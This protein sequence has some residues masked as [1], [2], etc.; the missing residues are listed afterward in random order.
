MCPN[1]HDKDYK[2]LIELFGEDGALAAYKLNGEQIPDKE[3]AIELIHDNAKITPALTMWDTGTFGGKPEKTTEPIID[4]LILSDPDAKVGGG[5]SFNEVKNRGLAAATDIMKTAPNGAIVVTNSSVLKFVLLWDKMGRPS[6]WDGITAKD[7]LKESTTPGQDVSM[8]GD[9]GQEITWVRHGETD[10][11]QQGVLRDESAVLVDKGKKD[12]DKIGNNLSDK[13]IPVAYI[14]PTPRTLQTADRILMKNLQAQPEYPQELIEKQIQEERDYENSPEYMNYIKSLEN[15]DLPS[16][17]NAI[18]AVPRSMYI[19]QTPKAKQEWGKLQKGSITFDQFLQNSQFPKEQ[20]ELLRDIYETEHPTT[21]GKLATSMAAKYSYTVEINTAKEKLTASSGAEEGTYVKLENGKY[22]LVDAAY[23]TKDEITKKE[24]EDF[25]NDVQIPTHHYS[26]LTVPGGTNYTENEISTP[27]IT[28]SIKGHAQFST[29]NGIGWFRSDEQVTGGGVYAQEEDD[30][31]PSV[32]QTYGGTPTKT[33]RILEV[34]SDLFQKGRDKDDLINK[35]II[36]KNNNPEIGD[37][38]IIDN[39][40]Y[41][42]ESSSEDGNENPN[43]KDYYK[44]YTEDGSSVSDPE[45]ELQIENIS[46]QEYEKALSI[47][48]DITKKNIDNLQSIDKSKNNFLQLLNKDGNW[49][50]FFIKSIV[51]DSA[52]KGYEKVLFPTGDTASKVEEHSTLE[53]FKRQK[54][55]RIKKLENVFKPYVVSGINSDPIS[56]FDTLQDA[57]TFVNDR[58]LKD[59]AVID[60]SSELPFREAEV[61]KSKKEIKQLQEELKRVETEGIAALKPI[62]D[63]YENRVGNTLKK[64]YGKDKVERIKDEHGNEWYQVVINSAHKQNIYYSKE[65]RW[66]RGDTTGGQS[67]GDLIEPKYESFASIPEMYRYDKMSERKKELE[68]EGNRVTFKGVSGLSIL[69][70][71]EQNINYQLDHYQQVTKQLKDGARTAIEQ[72]RQSEDNI[73]KAYRI[74][75]G[76]DS[77]ETKGDRRVVQESRNDWANIQR[78]SLSYPEEQIRRRLELEFEG[79]EHEVFRDGDKMIKIN[80]VSSDNLPN[81]LDRL[82]IHNHM[83]P[84]TSYK[85]LGFISRDAKILPVVEQKRVLD[86]GKKFDSQRVGMRLFTKFGMLPVEEGAGDH[87]V[88]PESGISLLD[89]NPMNVLTEKGELRFIDPIIEVNIDKL[90]SKEININKQ[91]VIQSGINRSVQ[92]RHKED[93]IR[94]TPS[95]FAAVKGSSKNA[96]REKTEVWRRVQSFL[97]SIGVNVERLRNEGQDFVALADTINGILQVVDGK[98]GIETLGHEATHFFLDLLPDD[99]PLLAAIIKDIKKREEYDDVYDRYKDDPQYQNADGSVNEEKMAKEA[100]AHIIDDAIVGKFRD[101][102]SKKW[103]ERLWDYIKKLFTGKSLDSFEQVAEDILGNKTEKLSKEKLAAMKEANRR[104]EI[105]FQLSDKQKELI[106]KGSENAT[107]VQRDIVKTFVT[108][109]KMSLE[110][111]GHDYTDAAHPGIEFT[112]VSTATKGKFS[113]DIH[114]VNRNIG[115]DFHTIMQDRILGATSLDKVSETPHMSPEVRGM[116]WTVANQIYRNIYT[117]GCVLL[118]EVILSDLDRRVAGTTDALKVFADDSWK[119]IDFKTSKDRVFTNPA[120]DLGVAGIPK[121]QYIEHKWQEKQGNWVGTGLTSNQQHSIQLGC[122]ERMV[123]K[124]AEQAGIALNPLPDDSETHHIY[125]Q[126]DSNNN[127]VNME[128]EGFIPHPSDANRD[129][130][131]KILGPNTSTYMGAQPSISD[132]DDTTED[133]PISATVSPLEPHLL[134]MANVI[135]EQYS[136]ILHEV[137]AGLSRSQ[138]GAVV[139]KIGNLTSIHEQKRAMN[140]VMNYMDR[141]ATAFG[142][143]I[144]DPKNIDDPNYYIPLTECVK[145]VNSNLQLLPDFLRSILDTQH[146]EKFDRVKSKLNQL[147]VDANIQATAFID[148]RGGDNNPFITPTQWKEIAYKDE[149]D[150]SITGMG[151]SPTPHLSN[152]VLQH[153]D[154]IHKNAGMKGNAE[155]DE[156]GMEWK[157]IA[158]RTEA[159]YGRPL[160]DTDFYD[161]YKLDATGK[162][163]AQL[164]DRPGD[165]YGKVYEDLQSDLIDKDGEPI[166]F[167]EGN[168]AEIIAHN[169]ALQPKKDA[170]TQFRS[171][172]SLS[173]N[174]TM[175]SGRYHHLSPEYISGRD[176][177]MDNHIVYDSDGAAVYNEWKPKQGKTWDGSTALA[178]SYFGEDNWEF[179][180]KTKDIQLK[181]EGTAN[182]PVIYKFGDRLPG[183]RDPGYLEFRDKYQTWS[184]Y[185]RMTKDSK[186]R[187]TGIVVKDNAYFPDYSHVEMNDFDTETGKDLRDQR[188]KD[189]Q[190]IDKQLDDKGRARLGLY[191][192]YLRLMKIG[193]EEMG[194]DW[195][196][197][198]KN[199]GLLIMSNKFI[200]STSDSNMLPTLK[201]NISELWGRVP[202]NSITTD[203]Q[204]VARMQ[205]RKVPLNNVRNDKE[206]ARLKAELLKLNADKATM[207]TTAYKD[208]RKELTDALNDEEHKTALKDRELNLIKCAMTYC[209]AAK[210][211][212]AKKEVAGQMQALSDLLQGRIAEHPYD[213]QNPATYDPNSIVRHQKTKLKWTGVRTGV[214][215]FNG[216]PVYLQPGDANTVKKALHI[217]RQFHETPVDFGIT[218]KAIGTVMKITSGVTMS[219]PFTWIKNAVLYQVMNSRAALVSKYYSGRYYAK[220]FG[221]FHTDYLTGLMK[222]WGEGSDQFGDKKPGSLM[223]AWT[224]MYHIG[225]NDRMNVE[226]AAKGKLKDYAFFGEIMNIKN[227]EFS[228]IVGLALS[229]QIRNS[230][231]GEMVNAYDQAHDYNSA[232]GEIK[233]KLGIDPEDMRRVILKGRAIQV[234]NQGNYETGDQ[235][236][237]KEYMIGPALLQFK[238]FVASAGNMRLGGYRNSLIFGPQ[239]GSWRTPANFFRGFNRANG[240]FSEKGKEAWSNLRPDQK[241]NMRLA[242]LDL[243]YL[244]LFMILGKFLSSVAQGISSED[245]QQ[246]RW[247]NLI[248]SI[249]NTIRFETQMYTPGIGVVQLAEFMENPIAMSTTLKTL[250]EAV[251]LTTEWPFQDESDR[252]YKNGAFIGTSKAAYQ[253]E[254]FGLRP[255]ARYRNA[256][257]DNQVGIWK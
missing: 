104:G 24:Y 142:K 96:Q 99:S 39:I 205:F 115:I 157:D 109:N 198:L 82:M 217:L 77:K 172:E 181:Y 44:Y 231:T 149:L 7:Y 8:K 222:K 135:S 6:N 19:A 155:A 138:L 71:I 147:N 75:K 197:A 257:V 156:V 241:V 232:T 180:P 93:T 25:Q 224:N 83:F 63:F 51:Q 229:S 46:K 255:I 251:Y 152:Q 204:G 5:E 32:L 239:E 219:N 133:A 35:S 112:P 169:L 98:A 18:R 66:Q 103:W 185:L 78:G 201:H 175:Q 131:N 144:N 116:A 21:V 250:A 2:E 79:T 187:P 174:G 67:Y 91:Y 167:T 134:H 52:K 28:P 23:N 47:A 33:R 253:W 200:K 170:M 164:L 10:Q 4:K 61:N 100:A 56:Y 191:N 189:L 166:N 125:I 195:N 127:V 168:S 14:S 88:N 221:L 97:K 186:G 165:H 188:W 136:S 209:M 124:T 54:E 230:I 29:E 48:Q 237:I 213:P 1:I 84:D 173:P 223:E 49:I 143:F 26:N 59:Y 199:G 179:V 207:G 238:S 137:N 212:K 72:G 16:S 126:F 249:A 128:Y 218:G 117:N 184:E 41:S 245:D 17:K 129:L 159:A 95:N 256:L 227:A 123:A 122:Y 130:V 120:K 36:D 236:L 55:D 70:P 226:G 193:S 196:L 183:E 242:G 105:Y 214:T 215:D 37:K 101:A 89:I 150:T 203:V 247:A 211:I 162:P 15:E 107:P 225:T 244:G 177:V 243:L 108:D 154:I 94:T 9:N 145:L 74:L 158:R 87:Y 190:G 178:N 132:T 38:V 13:P 31:G 192:D 160:I 80:K 161:F 65:P 228:N 3:K 235:P 30:Y 254:K 163:T 216:N 114:T 60:K 246:K 22:Y 148:R 248:A 81:Y 106:E 11:N 69:P 151:L 45:A 40:I 252:N 182:Q 90:M 118:P 62:Y 153:M 194:D 53:E 206:V 73:G 233:L 34:Q 43:I 139:N 102:Q 208:K 20:K 140:V 146:Q 121:D 240:S 68:A 58:G 111:I 210:G 110:P 141:R 86:D 113:A 50:P 42:Y 64:I 119:I 234:E 220:A 85:L 12:A 202:K 171:A 76:S 27:G 176:K 57:N 92:E